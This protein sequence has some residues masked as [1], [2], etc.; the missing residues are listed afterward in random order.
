LLI[1]IVSIVVLGGGATLLWLWM[2]GAIVGTAY[3]AVA[4]LAVLSSLA[5]RWI[6]LALLA[7]PGPDEPEDLRTG[8]VQRLR[9]P[10]GA[11]LSVEFYGPPDAPPI[12]MAPGWGIDSTEFYYLKRRLADRFRLITWDP[13]GLGE[14]R[15][16]DDDHYGLER[17]A[18]DLDAVLNVAGNRPALLV[19]HSLGGMIILTFY[20]TLHAARDPR[21]LGLVLANTTFTHPLRTTTAARLMQALQRPVLSPLLFMTIVLAPVVRLTNLLSYWNGTAQLSALLSGFA[22]SQSRGQLDFAARFGMKLSPAVVARGYLA[23]FEFDETATLGQIDKPTLILTSDTDRV[24]VPEASRS[25]HRS[26]RGSDLIELRGAGHLS[27]LEQYEQFCESIE[28][29]QARC[30]ATAMRR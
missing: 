1:G 16:P 6:V 4:G 3:L 29:F 20:R 30:L 8:S 14:S 25:M 5:G 19:G 18:G 2:T 7:R 21:V 26:I 15:G 17:M 22:G 13:R 28:A 27:L 9:R 11:E 12:V 23:T 24:F 10:D